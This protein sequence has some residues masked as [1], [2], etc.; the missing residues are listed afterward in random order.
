MWFFQILPVVTL[1]HLVGSITTAL[2]LALNL[3]Q[4]PDS[5]PNAFSLNGLDDANVIN[6]P[7][8]EFNASSMGGSLT[9][10]SLPLKARG[11]LDYE[12]TPELEITLPVACRFVYMDM[13]D[14]D[15]VITWGDRRNSIKSQ[16]SLP[17][18][19]SSREK[20]TFL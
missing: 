11:D 12:C 9:N 2:A 10:L 7:L 1:G 15:R 8:L 3:P 19:M 4:L 18:R 6:T 16:M 13:P 14:F 17:V 20:K 5:A